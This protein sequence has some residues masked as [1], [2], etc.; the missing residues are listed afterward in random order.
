MYWYPG[1]GLVDL[2]L[3]ARH[4][5]QEYLLAGSSYSTAQIDLQGDIRAFIA[6][7]IFKPRGLRNSVELGERPL[8]SM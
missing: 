8:K 4:E 5:V 1:G 2:K 6:T 7:Y 3:L